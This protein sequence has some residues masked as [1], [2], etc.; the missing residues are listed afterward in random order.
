MSLVNLSLHHGA[1]L[2]EA[3]AQLA[4]TAAEVR[5]RFGQ[6]VKGVEW[7]EDRRRVKFLGP[8]MW[9]E[10]RVDATHVHA[11]GDIP[12]VSGLLGGGVKNVL[13]GVL[14]RQFPKALPEK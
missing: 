12:A 14:K 4:A 6:F 7:G 3:E 5:T 8:G 1:T 11:E 2:P 10:M 13:G 9:V